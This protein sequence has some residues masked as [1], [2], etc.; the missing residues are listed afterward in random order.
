MEVCYSLLDHLTCNVQQGHRYGEANNHR[1][2]NI[3][4]QKKSTY[5]DTKQRQQDIPG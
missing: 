1:A 2:H 5:E 3:S 4:N